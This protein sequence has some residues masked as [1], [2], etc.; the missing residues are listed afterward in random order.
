[1]RQMVYTTAR[2]G[3]FD[4]FMGRLQGRAKEQGTSVGFAERALAGLSAGGLGE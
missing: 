2:L 3:F 1:L 4:T